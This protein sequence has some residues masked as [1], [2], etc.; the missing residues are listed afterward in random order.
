ME[1][2]SISLRSVGET[3]LSEALTCDLFCL[4]L[5]RE[6]DLPTGVFATPRLGD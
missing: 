1:A 5:R 3:A 2:I 4:D 6:L